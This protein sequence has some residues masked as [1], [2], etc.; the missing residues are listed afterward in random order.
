MTSENEYVLNPLTNR[1]VKVNGKLYNKL[2]ADGV[3]SHELVPIKAKAKAVQKKRKTYRT[4]NDLKQILKS[5]PPFKITG[6]SADEKEANAL[7][8][9]FITLF[10]IAEKHVRN[11]FSYKTRAKAVELKTK[12]HECEQLIRNAMS[13]EKMVLYKGKVTEICSRKEFL[14]YVNNVSVNLAIEEYTSKTCFLHIHL[15]TNQLKLAGKFVLYQHRKMR[16]SFWYMYDIYIKPCE[17]T[18]TT[19]YYNCRFYQDFHA[20]ND[21]YRFKAFAEFYNLQRH[22]MVNDI[23]CYVDSDELNL[24]DKQSGSNYTTGKDNF[25]KRLSVDTTQY[26]KVWTLVP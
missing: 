7:H 23:L 4:E 22:L 17:S 25:I 15:E 16:K 26:E 3:I 8:L 1:Q 6:L 21:E 5:I 24:H 2:V 18:D 12:I 13:G 11:T 20:L 14:S 19:R 9:T 10:S